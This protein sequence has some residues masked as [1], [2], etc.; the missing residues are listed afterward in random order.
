MLSTST[1]AAA[2]AAHLMVLRQPMVK[3][4]AVI[5]E[6][7]RT[8]SVR[9]MDALEKN[10]FCGLPDG[11]FETIIVE[12]SR[13]T[14]FLAL[15]AALL[16]SKVR[17]HKALAVFADELRNFSLYLGEVYGYEQKHFDIPAVSPRS[18]VIADALN[19]FS[20]FS[21]KYQWAENARFVSEILS[22]APEHI[23]ERRLIIKNETR[24]MDIPFIQLGDIPENPGVVII[25]DCFDPKK[26]YA[27]LAEF[28][29]NSLF[30]CYAGVN[31]PCALDIP[32][33]E[34]WSASDGGE[35]IFPDWEK[36]SR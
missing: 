3:E 13:M 29:V 16:A 32:V 26:N 15:N 34:C 22:Y 6:E 14:A 1:A 33:R 5:A 20:A 4:H 31:K 30:F 23:H 18:G 35:L 17:E 10:L 9:I 36:L 27:V 12:M 21:G 8:I 11:E 25:S 24:D 7:T 28:N 19:V 2:E